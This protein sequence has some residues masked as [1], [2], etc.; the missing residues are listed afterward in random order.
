MKFRLN[1]KSS[2]GKVKSAL[3]GDRR[4]V[5]KTF[6]IISAEN[7]NAKR[8]S[9][10]EN[11]QHDNRMR[12]DIEAIRY[13]NTSDE[14]I[15]ATK[16]LNL[17]YIKIKGK[18]GNEENSF[19]IINLSFDDALY[20][21][22]KYSQK[23][24]F[25]GRC[26]YKRGEDGKAIPDNAHISYYETKNNG[27]TYDLIETSNTIDTVEDADD[28][29]S[30]YG[31]FKWSIWLKYFNENFSIKSITNQYFFDESLNDENTMFGR[32]YYRKNY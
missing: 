18:F 9:D 19:M 16:K 23:S 7:P 12:K 30:K 2:V 10:I 31:D 32:V 6:A 15:K 5:I 17:Q 22:G 27:K 3:F 4:D 28:F 1:E 26:G 11:R 21:A 29:F 25:F 20:L 24:F 14:L 8:A 13:S